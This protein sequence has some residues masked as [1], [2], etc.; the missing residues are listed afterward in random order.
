MEIIVLAISASMFEG[1]DNGVA[2][3]DTECEDTMMPRN[4]GN[5]SYEKHLGRVEFS[6]ERLI[7]NVKTLRRFGTSRNAR[8]R[9][10]VTSQNT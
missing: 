1:S 2:M 6:L 10:S 3:F 9:N 5:Y 7:L 4:V 8:V